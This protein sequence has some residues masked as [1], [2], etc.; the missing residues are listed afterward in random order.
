MTAAA[1]TLVCPRCRFSADL[2]PAFFGCPR[3]DAQ[4]RLSVL[5]VHYPD[6]RVP[7]VAPFTPRH[8]TFWD[9]GPRLPLPDPSFRLSLGEGNTPLVRSHRLAGELGIPEV[10]LKNEG[11]NPTGSFKDRYAAVTLSMACAFG[12]K[13]VVVSSTGNHGAATAA[14]A[15]AAGL[16]CLVLG[17]P[18][19]PAAI[20]EQISRSG[21]LPVIVD[22][23]DR[24]SLVE[25]LAARH[26]WFPAGLF[27]ETRVHNPFGV[28][29]YKT[30]A[31]EIVRDLGDVPDAVVFPSARGN[32]LF[33]AWKGFNELMEL[34]VTRRRPRM[35]ACQPTAAATIERSLAAGSVTRVTPGE[36][37]AVS[38]TEE[39]ADGCA[40]DAVRLSGG[41]AVSVDDEAALGATS[42]LA[43]DGL[44]V[45]VSSGVAVAGLRRLIE[46][47]RLRDVTRVV[48][49]L[50]GAGI[51]W[52][53]PAA[54]RTVARI[55]G[56]LEELERV[57]GARGTRL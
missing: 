45:E 36:S 12:F 37:V 34:G 39:I 27:L 55:H 14:Y 6:I 35:I 8:G 15:A 44:W 23:P 26:G 40:V 38:I 54:G 17:A 42:A 19:M 41:A 11:A 57:L 21:A 53:D 25:T 16:T 28:E 2:G 10:Y 4:N 56:L 7:D 51:K 22:G 24:F 52:C 9:Y 29:A 3:C 33:G 31:Y 32:G 43:A 30:I 47:G 46:Q 20:V 18:R 1:P 5:H 49:I 48:V 13:K 50:T